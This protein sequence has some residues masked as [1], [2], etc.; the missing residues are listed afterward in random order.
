MLDVATQP[1]AAS[2]G[3]A[4][5]DA[6]G[7]PDGNKADTPV[8]AA[9]GRRSRPASKDTAGK[10]NPDASKTDATGAALAAALLAAQ[11]GAAGPLAAGAAEG[12]PGATQEAGGVAAAGKDEGGARRAGRAPAIDDAAAQAPTAARRTPAGAAHAAASQGADAPDHTHA[13]AP[14]AAGAAAASLRPDATRREEPQSS[15]PRVAAALSSALQATQ[16]GSPAAPSPLAQTGGADAMAAP[17][18][19]FGPAGGPVA[20]SPLQ[21]AIHTGPGQAGFADQF[22]QHVAILARNGVH[23][24]ELSLQPADLGPVSVSIRMHGHEA[25]LSI[26]AT[27]EATRSAL[28]NALPRLREMFTASGLQLTGASVGDGSRRGSQ[29]PDLRGGGAGAREMLAPVSAGAAPAD[30]AARVIATRLIDT[31]A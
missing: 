16:G 4:R 7:G 26:A 11:S 6:G 30:P 12:E 15:L 5:P 20:A 9:G 14:D 28:E 27:H 18:P 25:T 22:S 1:P 10:S 24:A 29:Q 21:V 17:A 31:F 2:D 19:A 13:D 23:S 3:A 8:P